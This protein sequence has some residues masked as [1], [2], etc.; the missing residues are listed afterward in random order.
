MLKHRGDTG[1]G[2]IVDILLM[3]EPIR[4]PPRGDQATNRGLHMVTNEHDKVY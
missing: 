3:D 4:R 1:H 2:F